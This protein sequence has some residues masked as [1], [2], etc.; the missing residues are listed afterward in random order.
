[1]GTGRLQG[2]TQALRAALTAPGWIIRPGQLHARTMAPSA[3]RGQVPAC[4]HGGAQWSTRL[5]LPASIGAWWRM[6]LADPCNTLPGSAPGMPS[7]VRNAGIC[8]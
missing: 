5:L 4:G 1:M 7:Q 2:H 6:V 8:A 3:V